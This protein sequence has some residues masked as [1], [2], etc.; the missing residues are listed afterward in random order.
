MSYD[1]IHD[2]L[3]VP[4]IEY[5]LYLGIGVG[6]TVHSFFGMPTLARR[7]SEGETIFHTD[8]KLDESISTEST[9]AKMGFWS[10]YTLGAGIGVGFICYTLQE[11]ANKN[12][13][14]LAALVVSNVFHYGSEGHR[15]AKEKGFVD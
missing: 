3:E 4:P 1:V 14:P 10:G 2:S 12:Y 13:T 5:C 15:W 7:L 9:P 6:K 11:F 8:D